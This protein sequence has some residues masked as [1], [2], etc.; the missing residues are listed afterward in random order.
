MTDLGDLAV[1]T[2]CEHKTAKPCEPDERFAWSIGT[3]AI[4]SGRIVYD[5]ARP[6][7][8]ATFKQFAAR[9]VPVRGDLILA[10][11]AP[12]GDCVLVPDKGRVCLGQRT[13]LISP[14]ARAVHFR[15]L[16]FLLRSPGVRMWMDVHSSGSTVKHLNVRD[17][18]R[19]PLGLLPPLEEQ[20]RIA[21]VLGAFDDLIETNRRLIETLEGLVH[22]LFAQE[23][24]DELPSN[25][26]AVTLRELISINPKT[27][28]PKGN[29]PYVDMAMLPTTSALLGPPQ[30]RPAAG[31]AK[32]Q[33]GDTLLA[34]ITPCLENGKTAYVT[35]LDDQAVAV[36]ST[37]FI[38]LRGESE[39]AGIWTYALARSPR[40]RG[41][42]IRQLGDGTS[43]RQRLSADAVSDYLVP[44]PSVD[45][46]ER[47]R[48][49]SGPLVDAMTALHAEA[50]DLTRQRD[51]LLPLLMSGKVRVRALEAAAS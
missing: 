43:G 8:E 13:V 36:G 18:Y 46:V 20:E 26:R 25:D 12:V 23:R 2:D 1:I 22:G 50:L 34:R 31:G 27:A 29:A 10:R 33:N 39:L 4:R 21:G 48:E 14:D 7:N 6:V 5:Q 28:K 30:T 35:N 45:A 41:F 40:F 38:V 19:I 47:F 51:E 37:E 15:F 17:I 16:Y 49:S 3:K 42:A 44:L 32:F 9:R 24:F 11:E